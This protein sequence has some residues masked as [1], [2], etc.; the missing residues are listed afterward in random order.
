[1][2]KRQVFTYDKK[3]VPIKIITRNEGVM[4]MVNSTK[5]RDRFEYSCE[6]RPINRKSTQPLTVNNPM[7]EEKMQ[8]IKQFCN[9]NSQLTKEKIN[10]LMKIYLKH[11]KVFSNKPGKIVGVQCKLPLRE[12]VTFNKRSYPCLLYTSRCV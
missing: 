6:D 11:Y 5:L 12:N 1:M 9:H 4:K 10:Q 3:K 8:E 2:Y 7:W